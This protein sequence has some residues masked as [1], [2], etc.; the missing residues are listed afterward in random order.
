M[1]RLTLA[2]AIFLTVV[3]LFPDFLYFSFQIPYTVAMFFGGTG[4]LIAVGVIL[5]TMK[6]METH[7]LEKQYD[8]FLQKG[9]A[10][11]H[12]PAKRFSELLASLRQVKALWISLGVLL[13]A[14]SV[15]WLIH[16]C[17]GR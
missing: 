16:R 9:K 10:R 17:V 11:G 13:A 2:G 8:G 6:Q 7:L 1:T 4:T 15:A 3:A 14:G 5:E 12:V